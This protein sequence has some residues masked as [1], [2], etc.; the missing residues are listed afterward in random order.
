MSCNLCLYSLQI[1]F[2]FLNYNTALNKVHIFI[3]CEQLLQMFMHF[4]MCDFYC[5]LLIFIYVFYR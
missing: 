4:L 3:K 1:F 5:V 2:S